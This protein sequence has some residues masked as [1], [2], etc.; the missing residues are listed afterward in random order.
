MRDL[1]IRN[2]HS[3][4]VTIRGETD[5]WDSDGNVV[6]LDESKIT[7]EV[8]RLQSEFTATQ[9]QR[10]RADSYPSLSDVTVALAEKEEGDLTMWDTITAERA[11]V[12]AKFPK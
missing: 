9:Y 1:A 11:A 10:D 6:E 5:A 4:V 8:A 7:T 12:K 2:T 3:T